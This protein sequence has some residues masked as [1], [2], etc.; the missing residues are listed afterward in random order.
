MVSLALYFSALEQV[1]KTQ[2]RPL[3]LIDDL[4]AELDQQSCE[5][6]I[7]LLSN[8][9]CQV[10]VTSLDESV[11]DFIGVENYAMFHVEHGE[12]SPVS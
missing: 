8:F 9:E 6:V 11:K 10:V 5:R 1:V 12:L 4:T 2:I 7:R 3:V